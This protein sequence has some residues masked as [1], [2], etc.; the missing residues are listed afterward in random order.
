MER[1]LAARK[2]TQVLKAAGGVAES[3]EPQ[4]SLTSTIPSGPRRQGLPA[5][6]ARGPKTPPCQ[7]WSGTL[8][9]P[10]APPMEVDPTEAWRG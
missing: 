2:M 10:C 5:T 8:W 4:R 9:G 3:Q 6:G 1:S 7:D